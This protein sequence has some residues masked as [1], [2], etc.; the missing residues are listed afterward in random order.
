MLKRTIT[1][2][3]GL[4]VFG[5][6]AYFSGT[7]VF[8]IVIALFSLIG[9]YEMLK[10][11]GAMKWPIMLP[12]FALAVLLPL[13]PYLALER[14]PALSLISFLVYLVLLLTAA[15]LCRGK[16]LYDVV[17]SGAV[18]AFY[19]AFAF[20][21]IVWIRQ[22]NN[23][24]YLCVFLVP[25]ISDMFAYLV[26]SKFG[27]HKLIPQISPNKTVEGS[28]AG[29]VFGTAAFVGLVYLA[30]ACFDP[31]LGF[32]WWAV[33]LVGLGISVIEQIG[34]LIASLIKRRYQVKDYGNLFP[35]H[36][37]VVDR[38]DSN[39]LTAVCMFL[40]LSSGIT[41]FY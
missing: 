25:W 9:V 16:L 32:R 19:V 14:F 27:R 5:V 40:L 7:I 26:G 21:A 10:C 35:G 38:F 1:T 20:A 13:L 4:I 24:L 30:R 6:V 31:S 12:S 22:Q 34:D 17:A 11:V 3:V 29:L 28:V 41:I 23:W 39:F 37:G 33:L 8:P 15:V 36:G 2:V 18:G